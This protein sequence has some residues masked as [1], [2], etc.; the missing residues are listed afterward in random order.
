MSRAVR[1]LLET[2][3]VFAYPRPLEGW[4]DVW[5]T[6]RHT[7]EDVAGRALGVLLAAPFPLQRRTNCALHALDG[8]D[9]KV[10]EAAGKVVDVLVT[11]MSR[12]DWRER[13]L[14]YGTRPRVSSAWESLVLAGRAVTWPR[15]GIQ[16]LREM[17]VLDEKGQWKH[18]RLDELRQFLGRRPTEPCS[19]YADLVW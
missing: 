8:R 5:W 10:L 12:H 9:V 7:W 13:M 14:S 19:S 2:A 1:H 15:L 11:E 4:G 3:G 18:E 6:G 16:R 17:A